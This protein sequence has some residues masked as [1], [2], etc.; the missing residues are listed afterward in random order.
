MADVLA[1]DAFA[2]SNYFSHRAIPIPPPVMDCSPKVAT[3]PGPVY[4]RQHEVIQ[5]VEVSAPPPAPHPSTITTSSVPSSSAYTESCSEESV[6]D[7]DEESAVSS[8][9]SSDEGDEATR[10]CYDDTYGT[11]LKRVLAWRDRAA[12][13]LGAFGM[14]ISVGSAWVSADFYPAH[15]VE[16]PAQTGVSLTKRRLADDMVSVRLLLAVFTQ[17]LITTCL[18][19]CHATQN[20]WASHTAA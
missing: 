3:G 17:A 14:F 6:S 18:R 9:C 12:K 20:K 16:S 13:A 19:R 15:T 8:Y 11:R 7:E 10:A 1:F 5:L 2:C 4:Y